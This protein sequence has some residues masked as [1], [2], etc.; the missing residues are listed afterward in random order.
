MNRLKNNAAIFALDMC[1]K[2]V[3][4]YTKVIDSCETLEQL[5]TASPWICKGFEN[6]NKLVELLPRR[7]RELCLAAIKAA[8][9]HVLNVNLSKGVELLGAE[10]DKISSSESSEAETGEK[11]GSIFKRLAGIFPGTICKVSVKRVRVDPEEPS[12]ERPADEPV[13][14]DPEGEPAGSDPVS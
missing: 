4:H 8:S 5:E 10:L 12:A 13:P 11:I 9:M 7:R 6:L 2:Q 14:S 1:T 3:E